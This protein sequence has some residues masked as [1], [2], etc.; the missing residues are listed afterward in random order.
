M[1]SLRVKV[2]GVITL[3]RVGRLSGYSH[4]DTMMLHAY[5]PLACVVVD[6][7]L[8]RQPRGFREC[9]KVLGRSIYPTNLHQMLFYDDCYE[10]GV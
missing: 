10:P 5:L 8:A 6:R 7:A 1:H 9:Q 3:P 2:T 4:D